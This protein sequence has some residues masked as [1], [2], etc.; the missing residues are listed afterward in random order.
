MNVFVKRKSR[1]L[2][3]IVTPVELEGTRQEGQ[4]GREYEMKNRG[5]EQKEA[6]ELRTIERNRRREMHTEHQLLEGLEERHYHCVHNKNVT[7][8]QISTLQDTQTNFEKFHCVVVNT[9]VQCEGEWKLGVQRCHQCHGERFVT[10]VRRWDITV[11]AHLAENEQG[12]STCTTL[13]RMLERYAI[14]Y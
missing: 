8:R 14:K 9:Y 2:S 11:L 6:K 1:E 3:W 7:T 5:G 12:T 10:H 4:T 13:Y